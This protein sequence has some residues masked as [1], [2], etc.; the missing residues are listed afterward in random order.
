M[1]GRVGGGLA[2][3]AVS[4]LAFHWGVANLELKVQEF[5]DAG[6]VK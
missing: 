5:T 1:L 3:G 4:V 2:R 6:Q